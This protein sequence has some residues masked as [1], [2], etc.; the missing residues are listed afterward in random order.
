[1]NFLI[2]RYFSRFFLNFSKILTKFSGFS[3]LKIDFLDIYKCTG[4]AAQS[5]ASD[6]SRSMIKGGRMTW[7]NVE[8]PIARLNRD[9]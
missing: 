7:R 2:F 1:M 6:Q 5:G 8:R 9:R 3:E 4:D